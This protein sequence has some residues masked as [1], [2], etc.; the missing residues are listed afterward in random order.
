MGKIFHLEA[1]Y[2]SGRLFKIKDGW[3]GK[4]KDYSLVHGGMIHMID[5]VMW[6]LEFFEKKE[7]M[8]YYRMVIIFAQK[9]LNTKIMILLHQL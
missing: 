8:R 2:E 7:Y 5:L 1:G 6:L 4:N 3:R 9:N